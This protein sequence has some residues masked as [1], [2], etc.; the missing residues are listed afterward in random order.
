MK[1]NTVFFH[2]STDISIKISF[3]PIFSQIKNSLQST[4]I[5]LT[6]LHYTHTHIYIFFIRANWK[7]I[8]FATF[9]EKFTAFIN[10]LP[11]ENIFPG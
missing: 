1:I 3:R 4:S 10:L 2:T 9:N 6:D 5:P 11:N 8:Y 7:I